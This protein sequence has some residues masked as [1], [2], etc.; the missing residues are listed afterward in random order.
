LGT[1]LGCATSVTFDGVQ[2]EFKVVANSDIVTS[3]PAGAKTGLV[4]V[5]SNA[6]VLAGNKPFYVIPKLT[7]RGETRFLTVAAL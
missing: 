5:S 6:S 1:D 7:A 2:A 4:K 3:V